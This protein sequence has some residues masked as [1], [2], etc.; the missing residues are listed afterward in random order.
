[1]TVALT[2][3]STAQ[4]V[5]SI[6]VAAILGGLIGLERELRGKSAGFRTNMLICVGSALLTEM[7]V[8]VAA[9]SPDVADPGRIA[10]Y[11]MGGIGFLGAGVIWKARGEVNGMTTAATIWV[12]AAIGIAVGARERAG[13][14]VATFFVLLTLA[15][16]RNLEDRLDDRPHSRTIRVEV[17]RH[18]DDGPEAGRAPVRRVMEILSGA[19]KDPFFLESQEERS[20]LTVVLCRIH[21]GENEVPGF[22]LKV[23]DHPEVA[24]VR[25][26]PH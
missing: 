23:S 22:L 26:L 18:G 17:R 5:V 24:G 4:V 9:L 8:R 11:V 20:G 14:T 6:L 3:P 13:A 7:S 19:G 12:I 21:L 25:M 15:A 2:A 10:S 1:M 16:L